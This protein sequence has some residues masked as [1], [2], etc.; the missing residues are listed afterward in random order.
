MSNEILWQ[1][2]SMKNFTVETEIVN[3]NFHENPLFT[4]EGLAKIIDNYPR[5]SL[6]IYTMGYNPNDSEEW[7]L[8]RR[9]E[10]T[11]AELLE[12]VKNGRLWLN[13]R[14]CNHHNP[15]INELCESLFKQIE[16]R[17][18]INTYKHD[19]GMLISSP[20]AH[21]SYHADMPLVLLMQLRG[22][23][24]IYLYPPS[25]PYI[26]N[27]SL[28]AI[29]IKER[30]E[31]LVLN[32]N[33]DE[34]ALIHDLVPGEFVTWPQNAPHR[35]VNHDSVNVSFSIE[36]LTTKAALRAN[37]L[38]ANGCFRRYYGLNPK[39]ENS[40]PIIDLPK[41]AYARIIKALGGYKGNKYPRKPS[42]SLDPKYLGQIHFDEGIN[43]PQQ[44]G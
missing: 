6:E 41:I 32:P 3:H 34:N 40:N 20:N 18:G 38:Y 42:F 31:Q 24:R 36:F 29:A 15:E 30:D 7:Y 26:E 17:T 9:G 12:A 4:D 21:V 35:I 19:M 44:I 27:E 23:K 2:N 28:E 8:G 10:L 5:E 39:I 13:L 1:S 11:S 22:K 33:W 16:D 37:T 43:P 25:A 14:K